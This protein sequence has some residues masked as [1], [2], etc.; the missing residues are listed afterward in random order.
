DVSGKAKEI[1]REVHETIRDYMRDMEERT[2]FNTAIARIMKLLNT[3]QRFEPKSE[4]DYKVLKEA[5]ETIIL[6][7]SPITPHIS[8]EMWE[9]LG[10]KPFVSTHPLP[11]PD[12]DALKVE[13]IQLPVQINGKV[14]ARVSVSPSADEQEVKEAVLSDERVRKWLEG[15]EIKKFIYVKGRL[16]SIVTG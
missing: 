16:V 7:L 8:E 12:P 9:L 2:Q 13:E 1:R 10:N 5:L 3:L 4:T 11:E 15:K 14:R 6:L